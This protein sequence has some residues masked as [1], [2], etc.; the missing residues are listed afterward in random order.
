M[1]YIFRELF[2]TFLKGSYAGDPG[3]IIGYGSTRKRSVDSSIYPCVIQE[4][5]ISV[6]SKQQCLASGTGRN[7]VEKAIC[8]GVKQGGT[9]A[10]DVSYAEFYLI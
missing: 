8:A 7:F 5:T 10:C 3:I 2:Y 6:F 1:P 4:A 9:D